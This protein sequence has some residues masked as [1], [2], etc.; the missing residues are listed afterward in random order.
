LISSAPATSNP[1]IFDENSG[2]PTEL[3]ADEIDTVNGMLDLSAIPF[4]ILNNYPNYD[5]F[6]DGV[7]KSTGRSFHPVGIDF[8]DRKSVLLYNGGLRQY[9]NL[10]SKSKTGLSSSNST[11]IVIGERLDR[12]SHFRKIRNILNRRQYSD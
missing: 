9:V 12:T 11:E 1:L 5:A 7:Y 3:T 6:Q 8:V 4:E 2:T 10:I